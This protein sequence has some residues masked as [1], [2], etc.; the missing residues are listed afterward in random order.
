MASGSVEINVKDKR[1]RKRKGRRKN[2][3]RNKKLKKLNTKKSKTSSK[4]KDKL[5]DVVTK[6]GMNIVKGQI[7]EKHLLAGIQVSLDKLGRSV[8]QLQ[9]QEQGN[10][11]FILILEFQ[12]TKQVE[13]VADYFG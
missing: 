9:K 12:G 7:F 13:R 3:K 8:R 2:K 10:N 6:L 5:T 11:I 4:R 1:K